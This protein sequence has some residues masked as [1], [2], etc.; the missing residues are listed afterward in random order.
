[1]EN[2]DNLVDRAVN[3]GHNIADKIKRATSV[4]DLG[5]LN[6]EIQGYM[7]FVD[8]NFGS[9][10]EFSENGEK[11]SELSFYLTMAIE[12]KERHLEYN[13]ENPG[14]IGNDGV[15]SFLNF[16]DSKQWIKKGGAE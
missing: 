11:Y 13:Y 12:E 2:S 15:D 14:E 1:M 4:S 16:L 7:D 3:E 5:R 8:E 10:D 6:N 9:K